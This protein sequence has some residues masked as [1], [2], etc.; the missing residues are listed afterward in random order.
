MET[1]LNFILIS[2]LVISS[3]SGTNTFLKSLS[4]ELIEQTAR[5]AFCFIN[6]N[7]TVYDLNPL[8]NTQSDYTIVGPDYAID[9]NICKKAISQC[10]NKTSLITYSNTLMNECISL[11]GSATVVS[12]WKVICKSLF[13]S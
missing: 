7:G 8:S 2:F 11:S 1:K 3:I 13:N 4:K 6:N 9:F 10:T 5:S 12:K